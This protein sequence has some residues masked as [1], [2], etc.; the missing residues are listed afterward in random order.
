M[1]AKVK[2]QNRKKKS[3]RQLIN[4]KAVT[5]YSLATYRGEEIAYFIVQ[6]T[7][8]SVLSPESLSARVFAL[9]NVLKGLAEFEM[10]CLDSRES[11]ENNKQYLRRRIA[12]EEVPEIR[13]LLERDARHLDMIQVQTATAREF[14]LL[15]RMRDLKKQEVFPF[16]GRVEKMVREQG[17]KTRRADA[18]DIKRILAVY[19]EQNVTTEHFEDYDGERWIR[20]YEPV[21]E[22]DDSD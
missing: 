14:L 13:T 21:R 18:D 16:L 17:F 5:G 9:M 2:R 15:V 6:P 8:L 19:F 11:F 4:T 22:G 3:T 10:L 1:R 7:N 20:L 12:E